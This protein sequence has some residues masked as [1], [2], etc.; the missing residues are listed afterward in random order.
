MNTGRRTSDKLCIFIDAMIDRQCRLECPERNGHE[1]VSD[2][3]G[4]YNRRLR[5]NAIR[6]PICRLMS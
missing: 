3:L 4:R 2:I 6:I 1:L 5:Y